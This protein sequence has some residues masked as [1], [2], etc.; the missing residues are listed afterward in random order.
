MVPPAI[1]VAATSA[2]SVVMP[3]AA[4]VA[5][6]VVAAMSMA[7]PDLDYGIIGHAKRI[8]PGD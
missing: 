6:S 5:P 4:A 2:P 1:M 7:T 8:W 3:P